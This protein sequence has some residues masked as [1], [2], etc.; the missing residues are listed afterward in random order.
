MR[1]TLMTEFSV[2][3]D[4][5][6]GEL[7]GLL[8]AFEH[9]GVDL[10]AVCVAEHSPRG[11]VR[12]VPESAAAARAVLEPLVETGVGP[13][14]ETPVVVIQTQHRPRALLEVSMLLADNRV[15]IERVYAAQ[16]VDGRPGRAV[17]AVVDPD[18]ALEVI[19]RHRF[20]ASAEHDAA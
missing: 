8:G 16:G 15:N 14:V 4:Q 2:Y 11:L 12:V 9:A 10:A 13:V 18:A 6:P 1:P 17:L 20:P 3:L 7:A 19:D 5:R